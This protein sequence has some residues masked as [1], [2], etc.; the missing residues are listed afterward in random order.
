MSETNTPRTRNRSHLTIQTRQP[1]A[2]YSDAAYRLLGQWLDVN[3][4]L[5]VETLEAVRSGQA[6]ESFRIPKPGRDEWREILDPY[7]GLKEVQRRILDRLL[8]PIPV[9]NAAHGAVPGRSVVTN[10]RQ[11]LPDAQYMLNID[12]RHAFPSVRFR[13]VHGVFRRYVRPLLRKFGPLPTAHTNG[14]DPVDEVIHLLASLCTYR[15][16]VRQR[17]QVKQVY[18]L[19]QGAPTSGYLLN[20]ACLELDGKIYKILSKHQDLSLRYSRYLDDLVLSSP[21][22][23]PEDLKKQIELAVVKNDFHLNHQKIQLLKAPSPLVVCGVQVESGRLTAEGA[24]ID[25]CADMLRNAEEQRNPTAEQKLRRKIRGV[26]AFF[27]QVYGQDLPDSIASSYRAYRNARQLPEEPISVQEPVAPV[28]LGEAPL[29]ATSLLGQWLNVPADTIQ[30]ARDRIVAG[31]GYETWTIDKQN[32]GQRVITSPID[33]VKDVQ[34][35]ILS[36]LI[37]HIPVS[38]ASHGFVPGRSIVTNAMT[39]LGAQH[40]INLDLK[41]AFPSVSRHRVE[42][43]LR[44]GLGRVIK[45]FGIR[46]ERPLRDELISLLGEL[47]TCNDQLPQGAPTSGYLLNI[48]SSSL[49]KHLF[50]LIQEEELSITYTRYADDLSF[51]AQEE[52]STEFLNKVKRV[53]RR[54]GFRWNPRKTHRASVN[55]GQQIELCG[56]YVDEGKLRLPRAKMKMYRSILR[57]AATQVAP[58]QLDE[59]TKRQIQGVVGFV[60]MVYGELPRRIA[61]PYRAFLQKHPEARPKR[62]YRDKIN[63]YP[64]VMP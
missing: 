15:Q 10:A 9:S 50:K 35:R 21:T 4:G 5:L 49:D 53:I 56:I 32:G 12:L 3:A 46:L 63:F 54:S 38:N 44:I 55:K 40:L 29:S 33:V 59:T 22:A 26:M 51:T 19:P 64:N 18:C 57:R 28:P 11:H 17:G 7:G 48:A 47:V 24:L 39:H 2:S 6:Y 52:L 36:Q 13:R 31:T 34:Q 37:Y 1:L 25:R 42:L 41:D 61:E 62:L 60:E 30:Q 43:S 8:Y 23:I 27:R 14:F 16:S 20:L 58:G 45:K